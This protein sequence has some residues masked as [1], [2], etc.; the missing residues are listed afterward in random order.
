MTMTV[1]MVPVATG[2][3]LLAAGFDQMRGDLG[4]AGSV[5]RRHPVADKRIDPGQIVGQRLAQTLMRFDRSGVQ[6]HHGSVCISTY[7]SICH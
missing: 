7:V 3:L 6:A 2:E 1:M 4:D 5:P